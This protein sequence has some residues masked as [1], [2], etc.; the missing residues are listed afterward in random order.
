MN[1]AEVRRQRRLGESLVLGPGKS[2]GQLTG[3]SE[4]SAV[5]I[6]I[7]T[8]KEAPSKGRSIRRR[9]FADL[10]R[11]CAL[12]DFD[13]LGIHLLLSIREHG[14]D[15]FRALRFSLFRLSLLSLPALVVGLPIF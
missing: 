5:A 13:S 1:G 15:C 2:T 11:G 4:A 10:F 6:F 3:F 8:P 9:R 12:S 7:H 14:P